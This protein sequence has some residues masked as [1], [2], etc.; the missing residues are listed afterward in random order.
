VIFLIVVSGFIRIQHDY[1]QNKSWGIDK[2]NVIYFWIGALGENLK[3]FEDE[4]R[5]NP[6][7][8]DIAY[9]GNIPGY[10]GMTWGRSFENKQIYATVWPVSSDFLRFFGVEILEGRNFEKEDT[11]GREKMIFNQTFVKTYNFENIVGKQIPGLNQSG[12]TNDMADIVGIAEDINFESLR[13]PIKPMAFITGKQYDADWIHQMFVRINGQNIAKTFDYIRNTLKKFTDADIWINVLEEAHHR[14]YR[15]EN[16]LAKLISIF[17]LLTIVVAIMGVYGMILFNA[18][19]KR[20][21]IALH[22]VNG[23]SKIDVILLLNHGFL[24]QFVIAYIIAVPLAYIV[25]R[26]WLENF[27]YQTPIHWW[28]FVASGLLVFLITVFTVSWQSYRAASINP[29]EA[30]KSE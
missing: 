15:Q 16:D 18:K 4:L 14:L 26:R 25:V 11:E 8:Y 3:T 19:S 7:I 2:E 28:V 21:L 24:I 30:I 5:K 1:L 17:G 23:A 20:K 29:I 12:E 22:K 27:A 10:V 6:D 9:T 13:E